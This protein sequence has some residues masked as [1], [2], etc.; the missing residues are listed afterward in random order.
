MKVRHQHGLHIEN[1]RNNVFLLNSKSWAVP[2]C[3]FMQR[4]MRLLISPQHQLVTLPAPYAKGIITVAIQAHFRTFFLTVRTFWPKF[5]VSTLESSYYN[6]VSWLSL[7]SPILRF[8]VLTHFKISHI[9]ILIMDDS[10]KKLIQ[11]L[12][13][14]AQLF[15]VQFSLQFILQV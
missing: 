10:Y 4:I 11:P 5:I 15:T 13:L 3:P 14:Y 8:T 7:E 1:V 6:N 9:V 2:V 12:H